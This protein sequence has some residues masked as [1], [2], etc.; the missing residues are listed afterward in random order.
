MV[1]STSLR[2]PE[3]F[4]TEMQA[5]MSSKERVEEA[6]A[7][8][9]FS[10]GLMT[11]VAI[12]P[13]FI[14]PSEWMPLATGPLEQLKSPTDAQLALSL[15]ALQYNQILDDLRSDEKSYEPFFWQ[16]EEERIVT[17]D[18][19]AGFLSGVRLR[20]EAWKAIPEPNY[21][22]VLG[23]ATILQQHEEIRAKALEAGLDPD[24]LCDEAREMAPRLIQQLYD[25]FGNR[26]VPE[27]AAMQGVK[28]KAGRND[29]CPCGS[30]KKYKK[31]CL[32]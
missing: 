25:S 3:S 31:C 6:F 27:L 13:E 11:A 28:Q 12:S 29:P 26:P 1:I 21:G 24:Q 8:L 18:C 9:S 16:D 17:K 15:T 10:N 2:D 23:M 19:A 20:R 32:N 14:R 7:H 22:L 5:F 4:Y 30:G